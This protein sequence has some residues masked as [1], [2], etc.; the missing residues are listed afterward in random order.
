VKGWHWQAVDCTGCRVDTSGGC[1]VKLFWG[2]HPQPGPGEVA[3]FYENG[4]WNLCEGGGTG[5]Q[6]TV[7]GAGWTPVGVYCE[8]SGEGIR[9]LA[10]ERVAAFYEKW[11]VETV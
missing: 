3:A 8:L 11:C 1:T 6:W 9:S 7:Q 4:A 2:G 10:L 5:R